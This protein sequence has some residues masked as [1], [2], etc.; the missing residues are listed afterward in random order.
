MWV[1]CVSF[2]TGRFF[3]QFR[4]KQVP[5]SVSVLEGTYVSF[6]TGRYICQFR[7]RKVLFE[8]IHCALQSNCYTPSTVHKITY[9]F[10]WLSL[11]YSSKHN[12]HIMQNWSAFIIYNEGR[13]DNGY[14][15]SSQTSYVTT[16]FFNVYRV[17]VGINF[18]LVCLA[19]IKGFLIKLMLLRKKKHIDINKSKG[20]LL[21]IFFF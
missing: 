4:Y 1:T 10:V 20:N 2:G 3:C 7:Y 18:C 13:L 11:V 6:G 21:F 9:N 8:I 12:K 19:V 16:L 17:V 14:S 5:M 15:K